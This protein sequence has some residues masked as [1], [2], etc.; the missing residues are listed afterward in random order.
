MKRML[1]CLALLSTLS[2]FGAPDNS[3][4]QIGAQVFIEPGQTA[5]DVDDWFRILEEN[6]LTVCRIRMFETHMRKPDGTYDFALYDEAFRA[7]ERHH[8]NVFAT[9]FPADD[10]VGGFKY[11]RSEAHLAEIAGFVK[12]LVTH[13]KA[14][15]ALYGWVLQN[16]PGSGGTYPDSDLARRLRAA[17]Q[18]AQPKSDYTSHGYRQARFD[19]EEFHR[20]YTTWF[21]NWYAEQVHAIDPGRHTHVNNHAIFSNFPEYDF[22]AWRKFLTT[23]GASAHPSWHYTMFRREQFSLAMSANNEI[24]RAGAG[25]L[26]FW[27]TELQGGNNLYSG[28]KPICPTKEETAQWLWTTLGCGAKGIIFWSLNPRAT[29]DEPG[30]WALITFQREASDRLVSAREVASTLKQN[31]DLFSNAKALRSGVTLLLARESFWT[32]KKQKLPGLKEDYEARAG[33]APMKSALAWYEALMESGI[34]A[35]LVEMDAFDWGQASFKGQ[36]AILAHQLAIPSRDW[37]RLAR[38]AERGGKLIV[39]GATGYFDE[40]Q[41]CTFMTGFPLADLLGGTISE[42]KA[43]GERFEV[44]MTDGPALPAHLWRGT[45]KN[46]TGT[47]LA[48]EGGEVFATRHAFGQGATLWIPSL[49][50]LGAWQRDNT[51]L[52]TFARR[53]VLGAVPALPVLFK[54][55]E[56][57][58]LLKTLVSGDS[59]IT[60]MINKDKVA[61]KIPLLVKKGLKPTVLFADKGGRISASSATLSP[62]ETLVAKWEGEVSN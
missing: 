26:P 19:Y 58:A 60:V 12:A 5:K 35:D 59:L 45:V 10:T 55:Q 1:L 46:A 40:H 15:P 25:P 50:G 2:L 24:I 17:W 18:A 48:T 56:K 7:A 20:S 34:P 4:P 8:I 23:L 49:V 29:I 39:E 44:P 52:A 36:V 14:F 54:R 13:F 41:V 30:E 9:L 43:L 42:F 3:L 32:D 6:G 57:L 38:F 62:E 53:E 51:A 11:P 33:G 27:L 16:E 31:A 21:L 22:P 37:P 47:P 28:G 61:K